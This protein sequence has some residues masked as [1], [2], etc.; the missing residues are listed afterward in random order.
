[1]TVSIKFD[2]FDL[3]LLFLITVTSYIFYT[4]INV[5]LNPNYPMKAEP[6]F[7][8]DESDK[9]SDSSSEDFLSIDETSMIYLMSF[10]EN[11]PSE[12]LAERFSLID[13]EFV[14]LNVLYHIRQTPYNHLMHFMNRNLKDYKYLL[15]NNKH[16]RHYVMEFDE[17][18][19]KLS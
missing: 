15:E 12:V 17:L 11:I 7:E 2:S 3:Y 16:Y 14:R 18:Q 5:Y 9:L 10:L 19:D 8:L 4:I 6:E 13:N 1:M